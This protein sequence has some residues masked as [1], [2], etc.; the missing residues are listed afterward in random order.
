MRA[1]NHFIIQSTCYSW[2]FTKMDYIFVSEST[3]TQSH[4][5]KWNQKTHA[6]IRKLQWKAPRKSHGE[7][8]TRQHSSHRL[9]LSMSKSPKTN[10]TSIRIKFSCGIQTCSN[11]SRCDL[12]PAVNSNLILTPLSVERGLRRNTSH[13]ISPQNYAW[14]P[15]GLKQQWKLTISV[16]LNIYIYT[17]I[18]Y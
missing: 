7:R 11:W 6:P 8:E 3:T 12:V 17:A 4:A 1:I 16:W 14:M 15:L 18:C 13:A 2:A 5:L 10:S 9:I